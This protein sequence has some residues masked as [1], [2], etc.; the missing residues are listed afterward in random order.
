M[1]KKKRS[2]KPFKASEDVGNVNE[3]YVADKQTPFPL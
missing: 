1:K 3:L 2:I